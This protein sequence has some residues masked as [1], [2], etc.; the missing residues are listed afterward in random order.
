VYSFRS[1]SEE[2][3]SKLKLIRSS[4]AQTRELDHVP[5]FIVKE[6]AD[7][8]GTRPDGDVQCIYEYIRAAF[9]RH[10]KEASVVPGLKKAGLDP[11]EI[12]NY[13]PI[14]KLSITYRLVDKAIYSQISA[15]L[16][17]HN[18]WPKL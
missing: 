11:S 13:R 5:T 10:K 7:H 6:F 8:V 4:V 9:P 16:S 17:E 2:F 1:V 15:Y 12:K 3:F 14:S 18:L